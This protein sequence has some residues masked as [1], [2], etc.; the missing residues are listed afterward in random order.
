[1]TEEIAS[2]LKTENQNYR[3]CYVSTVFNIKEYPIDKEVL[4]EDLIDDV[5]SR[6]DIGNKH[7]TFKNNEMLSGY[8]RVYYACDQ[9]NNNDTC[10]VKFLK[11]NK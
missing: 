11:M 1:M 2:P 3:P 9:I 8:E 5:Y 7:Y 4:H 10:V 6:V